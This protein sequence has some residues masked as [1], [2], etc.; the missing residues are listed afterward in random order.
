MF[1]TFS[2][3]WLSQ[4]D[5]VQILVLFDSFPNRGLRPYHSSWVRI[6]GR[7]LRYRPKILEWARPNRWYC[8][9]LWSG[10]IR[11]FHRWI[12]CNGYR[13]WN[14]WRYFGI[15]DDFVEASSTS[16]CNL[17]KSP[18]VVMPQPCEMTI[19]LST[20][21][22]WKSANQPT[23]ERHTRVNRSCSLK[24]SMNSFNWWGGKLLGRPQRSCTEGWFR[25][26][27][28]SWHSFLNDSQVG[29]AQDNVLLVFIVFS[30]SCSLPCG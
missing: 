2:C 9:R 1:C 18:S 22:T 5:E 19:S 25:I 6:A 3:P 29:P 30:Q 14:R 15:K 10:R 12:P 20:T 13:R 26:T 11:L 4:L 21:F 17:S 24:Y 23:P 27:C 7:A 16:S 28:F 8:C